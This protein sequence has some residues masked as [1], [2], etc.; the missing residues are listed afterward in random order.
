ME[1]DYAQRHQPPRKLLIA[2]GTLVTL[3]CF[4]WY[5]ARTWPWSYD[6]RYNHGDSHLQIWTNAYEIQF[7]ETHHF[8]QW[9]I[10]YWKLLLLSLI[11]TARYFQLR[12]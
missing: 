10:A 7:N 11:P 9:H 5:V 6:I 8:E 12:R 4:A 3:V 2:S 1:L